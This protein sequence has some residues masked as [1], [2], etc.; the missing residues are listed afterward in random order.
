MTLWFE[1]AW[2]EERV[3]T[4]KCDTWEEVNIAIQDFLNDCMCKWPDKKPFEWYYTRVW[5]QGDGRT[6]IDI[7]SHS[8]FFIWEGKYAENS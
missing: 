7:G 2:G 4:D 5:E 1:N 8:E 6:R 3:L